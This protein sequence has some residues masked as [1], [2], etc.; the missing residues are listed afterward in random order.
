M[1]SLAIET[2][3]TDLRINALAPYAVTPLT[4]AWFA[5]ADAVKFTPQ[6]VA[7]LVCW[8]VSDHCQLHGKT[9][10]AGGGGVRLSY[11]KETETVLL[12]EKPVS[13]LAQL[14]AMP[15]DQVP[16]HASEEF[17]LFSDSLPRP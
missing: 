15:A 16:A 6:A 14:A 12:G 8:L 5:E 3:N 4:R 13:A 7:E 17:Q 9:I 11:N 2:A 1:R 10:I